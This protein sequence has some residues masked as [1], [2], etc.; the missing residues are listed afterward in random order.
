METTSFNLVTEPWI[1][2]LD[3]E[4]QLKN[5][6]LL[7]VFENAPDYQRLAGDMESQDL[8][9]LRLL[10]AV[11][12]TV[13]SRVNENDKPYEW[14]SLNERFQVVK[15]DEDVKDQ[16]YDLI[17]TWHALYKKGNFSQAISQYLKAHIDKFNFLG[18]DPFY[19]VNKEIY[20]QEVPANKKVDLKKLI[21][22]V[23]VK[24]I[25]R[26]VS[27]SNNSLAIFSPKTP[28]TKNLVSL[29]QLIRWIIMYQSFTGVTDKT[30]VTSKE[31]FSVSAG[32]LYGLNPVF[33]QGKNLFQTLMLNLVF[34]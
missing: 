20:N 13:Y 31:K 14:L 30:K 27:E 11:L 8:T 29:P 17:N 25:N 1:Q 9:I 10:I 19:Q 33:A 5:V 7:E 24:Q 26:T 3:Q 18:K 21:G 4:G 34:F 28:N 22:T 15:I 12:T 2:V 6:S 23:D 32:W 16:Y